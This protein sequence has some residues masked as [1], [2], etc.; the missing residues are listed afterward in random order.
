VVAEKRQ[1]LEEFLDAPRDGLPLAPPLPGTADPTMLAIL[2]GV[3]ELRKNPVSKDALKQ[4]VDLQRQE[5]QSV[6]QAE[7]EPL[8]RA[9][10]HLGQS[11]EQLAQDAVQQFDRIGR[12]ESRFD[13]LKVAGPRKDDSTFRKLAFIG[14]PGNISAI[15][16][17]EEWVATH[18]K[19]IRVKVSNVHRGA[20]ERNVLRPLTGVTLVEFNDSDIKRHVQQQIEADPARYKCTIGGKQISIKQAKSE[21]ASQRDGALNRAA[22]VVKK[23][24]L[25]DF[26]E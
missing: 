9:V 23:D 19:D 3:N 1:S 24:I 25:A 18:F 14:I 8:H 16:R 4:I 6:V 13:A 20:Y 26:Q 17:I 12:L 15:E 2:E 11:Y 21:S 5:F 7:N 10:S 22:D